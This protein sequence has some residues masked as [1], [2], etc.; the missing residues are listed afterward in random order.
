MCDLSTCKDW[1]DVVSGV[2]TIAAILIGGV[3]TYYLFIRHRLRFPRANIEMQVHDAVINLGKLRAVHVTLRITNTGTTLLKPKYAELRLRQVAPVH[4]DL[5]E[6]I[7]PDPDTDPVEAGQTELPW[8]AL[9][10]REWSKEKGVI[11]IEPN[12]SEAIEADFVIPSDLNTI[13]LYAFLRNPKKAGDNV[14]WTA[15]QLH[16]FN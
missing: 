1:V 14:G 6:I 9:A 16:T 8:P 2:V 4:I 7:K 5:A 10:T 12:E 13:Q 15:T 11:E 3:W